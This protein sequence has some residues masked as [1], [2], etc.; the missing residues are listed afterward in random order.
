MAPDSRG[1]VSSPA[2]PTETLP[3]PATA[4]LARAKV[5]I[6]LALTV[7][8]L[9]A[10]ARHASKTWRDLAEKG[11][12]I[13]IRPVP[14]AAAIV[15][16]AIGLVPIG[17]FY[18]RV[19]DASAT[20]ISMYAA[21]RAYFISH[22]GKY[23]PGKALVVVMRA[24]LSSPYGA[25]V[26]TSA[27]A[28]F[29]ETLL[30]MAAGG[31]LSG[32]AFGWNAIVQIPIP[33]SGGAQVALPLPLLG[34][35]LGAMMLVFVWPSVFPRLGS[36]ARGPFRGVG[37]DAIPT[38]SY[39]LLAEGLL[40]STIGWIGLGLSQVAILYAVLPAGLPLSVWPTAIASVALATVA[41][42]VIPISPGGLGVREYVLWTALASVID[43]DR[44]VIAALVLRLAWVI[45]EVGIAAILAPLRPAPPRAVA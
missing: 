20:P 6:K 7:L 45:G 11:E 28:T 33:L 36:I 40:L 42:F 24:G 43:R 9:F 10:V 26:S 39:R 31:L 38:M 8:V 4:P 3:R 29:Y 22:L 32:V 27:F 17:I 18:G 14:F 15:I 44:A 23:V 1:L 16:Y 5:V 35:G 30:M 37:S 34:L 13:A 19:M 21:V 25:R 2:T 41:G 12:S